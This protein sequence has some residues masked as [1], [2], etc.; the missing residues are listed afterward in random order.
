M[1][2]VSTNLGVDASKL[3]LEKKKESRKRSRSRERSTRSPKRESRTSPAKVVKQEASQPAPT[4]NL[5]PVPAVPMF[6]QA[7]LPIA[8]PAFPA[9]P[10]E[11]VIV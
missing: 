2:A 9:V 3:S 10:S 5:V 7:D 1:E 11:P 8:L 4:V 6:N